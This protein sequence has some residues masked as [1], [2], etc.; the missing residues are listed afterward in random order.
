MLEMKYEILSFQKEFTK[1]DE[2]M[3]KGTK[4]KNFVLCAFLVC[5]LILRQNH[6]KFMEKN[7]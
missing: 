6:L 7:I 2:F 1:N 3:T 4:I 5:I